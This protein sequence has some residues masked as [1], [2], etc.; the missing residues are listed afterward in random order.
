MDINLECNVSLSKKL[1]SI[2]RDSE[3]RIV[4]IVDPVYNGNGQGNLLISGENLDL[5]SARQGLGKETSIQFTPVLIKDEVPLDKPVANLFSDGGLTQ[6]GHRTAIDRV[7]ATVPPEKNEVAHAITRAEEVITPKAF[8][9]TQNTD[10]QKFVS[11]FEELMMAIK[12]AQGKESE[13]NPDSIKDHRQRAIAIEMKEKAEAIDMPAYIV[14]DSY[15]SVTLNDINLNLGLNIPFN[16]SNISAKRL[17]TSGDLK[18]MLRANM[19]KF[20]SPDEVNEYRSLAAGEV[21]E[22]GLEVYSTKGEA[23]S[24]LGVHTHVPQAEQMDIPMDDDGPSEQQQ[25]AGLINL[26]PMSEGTGGRV[27]FHGVNTMREKKT[28]GNDPTK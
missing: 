7:A 12:A 14:N 16:L 4:L 5:N 28:V 1:R 26:T 18:A 2:L 19:I 20:I 6:Q 24:A 27:S 23:E 15:S 21:H 8:S 11:N 10:Y 13:I 25:L 17:A 9:E 22:H 3:G